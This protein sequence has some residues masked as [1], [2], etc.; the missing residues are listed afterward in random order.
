MSLSRENGKHW[1]LQYSSASR[2]TRLSSLE[3]RIASRERVV[4]YFWAVLY[5]S[6]VCSSLLKASNSSLSL[7]TSFS[8][9]SLNWFN[10]CWCSL[11]R[12]QKRSKTQD[13]LDNLDCNRWNKMVSRTKVELLLVNYYKEW[14]RENCCYISRMLVLLYI[15]MLILCM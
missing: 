5:L 7:L 10:S 1:Y 11:K 12:C 13:S 15:G 2:E 3:T 8:L 9:L 14:T 4:T 6:W